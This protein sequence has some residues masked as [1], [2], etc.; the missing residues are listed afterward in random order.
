MKAE[1]KY[2]VL[3]YVRMDIIGLG[4]IVNADMA[5]LARLYLRARRMRWEIGRLYEASE[6][7]RQRRAEAL[8][9][10]P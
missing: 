9:G 5:A 3:K 8:W 2:L 4:H 7:R 6:Q 10:Y 1:A